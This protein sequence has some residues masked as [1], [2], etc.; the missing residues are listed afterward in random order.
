V[1]SIVPRRVETFSQLPELTPPSG[2]TAPIPDQA[3]PQSLLEQLALA[4]DAKG[5]TYCQWKGHWSAHRWA[6]GHGDVDLLVARETLK[7]FREVLGDHGFKLA[8]PGADREIPG[9]ETYFGYDPSVSRLLHLHVHYQLLLGEY[10]RPVYRIPI[11]RVLL[12]SAVPGQPFRTPSPTYQFLIFVLRMMLRQ[13]GRPLLSAR[14]R[15][16]HGIQIQLESL[17]ACSDRAE[18]AS[19]LQCHFPVIDL[20]FFD[21]C[22]RSLRVESSPLDGA[23]LPWLLHRRLRAHCRLP[24]VGALASATADKLAHFQRTPLR[25]K[26]MRP[27]AGGIVIALVGGD[28]AGKSTCARELTHWLAPA[29]PTL[30]AHL[31]NPPRSLL[32]LVIGGALK[33][34]QG[35]HRLLR[36]PLWGYHIE[37]LR[38]L[39]TARDRHRL[40]NRA[41]RFA[42]RGGIAICERYPIQQNRALVGPS[43]QQGRKG[44]ANWLTERLRS[45]EVAYYER[46]LRPDILCV[47]RLDPELAVARKPE[48]PADYVRARARVIWETDWSCTEAQVVDASQPLEAVIQRLK[49]IIWS[50]L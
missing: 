14:K 22:V 42:G 19:V 25:R 13:I 21:R 26:S 10:W 34:Q 24:S 6:T 18:L 31:G 48:E 23:M 12:Q 35:L 33:L 16:R 36:R 11:E 17:E 9:V 5:V 40:Y 37:S 2:A 28:G 45:A 49:A 1:T 39:C 3:L 50:T 20:P 15:W 29:Y 47:L 38:H 44:D 27:A 41:H 43:I 7:A 46:I 8:L 4:L 30:R 32:T